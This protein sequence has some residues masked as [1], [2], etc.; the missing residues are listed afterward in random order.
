MSRPPSERQHSG[1]LSSEDESSAALRAMAIVCP[2]LRRLGTRITLG[3][4]I[5]A[6]TAYLA[7]LP[8]SSAHPQIADPVPATH[9]CVFIGVWAEIKN[10][11]VYKVTLSES[12]GFV[13]EPDSP[14]TPG[15]TYTGLWEVR[16]DK[17]EWKIDGAHH[18]EDINRIKN[19]STKSFTLVDVNG[20]LT[21]FDLIEATK[22]PNCPR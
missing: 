18:P 22:T 1:D 12:G 15:A 14:G 13:T 4:I 3:N 11:T 16:G 9:P 6:I 8:C 2:P 7:F 17:L 5:V 19:L 20:S 21:A 10:H